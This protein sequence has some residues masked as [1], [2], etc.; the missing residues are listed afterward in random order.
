MV[1]SRA[2]A[3]GELDIN[4]NVG[5]PFSSTSRPQSVI[6]ETPTLLDVSHNLA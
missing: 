5:W 1:V 2:P 3:V 4:N 6:R